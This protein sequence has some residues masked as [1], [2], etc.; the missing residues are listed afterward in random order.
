[1]KILHDMI[2]TALPVLLALALAAAC[3]IDI[4][5][6][7]EAGSATSHNLQLVFSIP[8]RA[9]VTPFTK[10]IDAITQ[11][12]SQNYFHGME[13]ITLIPFRVTRTVAAGD[14][15]N[16]AIPQL[17]D[18]PADSRA[19]T[20]YAFV[21][22]NFPFVPL[23][24]SSFL[25][26][27]CAPGITQSGETTDSP[28][29][30]LRN[31]SLIAAGLGSQT[32]SG[33]SFSPEQIWTNA[34]AYPAEAATMIGLLNQVV[35]TTFTQDNLQTYNT[36]SYGVRDGVAY[37]A[38]WLEIVTASS[39]RLASIF[40]HFVNNVNSEYKVFGAS[41]N[42]T[43]ATLA[44]LYRAL[45]SYNPD[46]ESNAN[47]QVTQGNLV[48]RRVSGSTI[49]PYTWKEVYAGIRTA[50]M[51]KI[52]SLCQN[53]DTNPVLADATLRNFPMSYGLPDGAIGARWNAG[54]N[55]FEAVA[56][57]T[58]NAINKYCYPPR[59]WYYDNTRIQT[60]T[61]SD[62][63]D[64]YQPASPQRYDR[65]NT[66]LSAYTSG[67]TVVQETQAIALVEPVQYAVAL[68][69]VTLK[70]TTATLL[71]ATA[72]P[73]LAVTVG[74]D[75]FPLTALFVGSQRQQAFDFTPLSSADDFVTYDG[76]LNQTVYLSSAGNSAQVNT[77]VLQTLPG[78]DVY[79]AA[80][81]QNN[82]GDYFVGQDGVVPNG[83]KFYLLGQLEF[84]Q[85]SGNASHTFNS[86]FEKD[87][88]TNITIGVS[89]LAKAR[90]VIPNL[91]TP[92]LD[93][94]VEITL[95]W[96]QATSTNVPMY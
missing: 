38:T 31:G 54:T 33:I 49:D 61:Q 29:F 37:T 70:Q 59:L 95:D 90:N 65:W 62:N 2:R 74:T 80:E 6:E 24:T 47:D 60:S 11:T 36:L 75:K 3:S 12:G 10:T 34:N 85:G 73:D 4:T 25:L 28:T 66:I 86:V 51:T 19:A 94:G 55:A 72:D 77:L 39:S 7:T 93:L 68:L 1:M 18:L 46:N 22:P 53:L 27:G 41:G 23:G 78:E 92:Q 20:N 14:P 58:K 40:N 84:S 32:P 82:S 69:T 30:K 48:Y 17:D 67:I 71:D 8:N 26:Y 52:A 50:L 45:N 64:Q 79:I 9:T 21:Y 81:F 43:A 88:R 63:V 89:S 16:G 83:G 15:K 96:Q 35:N 5:P 76:N 87:F 13:K 42:L 44:G 91:S 57:G 56:Q